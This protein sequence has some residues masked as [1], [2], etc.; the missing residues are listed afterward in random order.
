M[1][2]RK[3]K[4]PSKG[5]RSSRQASSARRAIQQGRTTA[6]EIL[7]NRKVSL[8]RRASAINRLEKK[9]QI[10][11]PMQ[12]VPAKALSAIGPRG[13]A[14]ILV[15]EG[16][17]WF[18]YPFNDV[19]QMLEDEHGFD[20]ESVAHK[21][22]NVEDMAFSSSQLTDFTRR[23][24]KL[25]RDG[26]IP[27]AILLS[28]GGND[29]AGSELAMLLNHARSPI[30]GFSD[31][32]LRGVIDE[33][34]RV[35]YIAIISGVTTICESY[36]GRRIPIIV[37]GYDY[38][39]PDGRGYLGGFWVLPGPW[40]DP[41]FR[42][43]GFGDRAKNTSMM[44]ELMDRFNDMLRSAVTSAGFD[45]VTYLDLRGTLSNASNYKTYWANE[46]HPTKAGFRLVAEKFAKTIA[47]L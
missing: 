24:E 36:L 21:G 11:R 32:V 20:V 18:D 23:L 26:K 8:K 27:R 46:L 44:K 15:A 29:I 14:G 30:S 35:S 17:S 1:A 19:L 4:R 16:D 41:S 37:H 25:L 42:K 6:K 9:G 2:A 12:A 10:A 3:I 47:A 13:S 5:K 38:S 22:D 34:I 45:H 31:S 7:A 28:G 40:L 43:K 33:R 39:V